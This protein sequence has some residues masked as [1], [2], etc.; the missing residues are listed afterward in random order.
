[1]S[2][3]DWETDPDYESLRT[4]PR[5]ASTMQ[6]RHCAPTTGHART[7]KVQVCTNGACRNDGAHATLVE[8]EELVKL[9]DGAGCR[10]EQYNCFGLCGRGPNVSID[11]NDGSTQMFSGARSTEQSLDIIHKAS[12]VRPDASPA[13]LARLQDLRRVSKLE[14]ALAKAQEIVDVL[15]VSSVE[16]RASEACQRKYD[17]ALARVDAVL[18]ETPADAHLRRLA[19]AVRRQVIAARACRPVSPEVEEVEVDDP[20]TW[21]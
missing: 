9:V 18:S 16:R 19:E 21:P 11:W 6:V 7:S 17:S 13:L 15:D 5:Q 8:L 3:D 14:Q 20:S 1:M 4:D 12:G 10:L 2:D